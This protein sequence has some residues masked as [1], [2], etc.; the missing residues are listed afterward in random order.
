M[1]FLALVLVPV[2]RRIQEPPGAGARI[3]SAAARRFLVV[4]WAAL[5]TLMATGVWLLLERGVSPA[6]VFTGHDQIDQSMRIKVALVA[7]VVLLSALHDFVLGP[8]VARKLEAARRSPAT[9]PDISRQRRLLSWLARFN[10]A[11][12]LAI[13][14]LGV[15][16]VRGW[17]L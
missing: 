3:L 7:L 8:R 12:A 13:V 17:P 2:I 5:L 10:V 9:D 11:L 1:L 14:A 6:E 15:V 16:L 4:A